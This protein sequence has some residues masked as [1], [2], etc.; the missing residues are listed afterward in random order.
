VSIEE[1]ETIRYTQ[2]KDQHTQYIFFF[3]FP[4]KP[5]HLEHLNVNKNATMELMGKAGKLSFSSDKTGTTLKKPSSLKKHGQH[6]W[7][8]KVTQP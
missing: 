4:D 5:V 6:V 3:E 7:V 8:V 1:G 2:S